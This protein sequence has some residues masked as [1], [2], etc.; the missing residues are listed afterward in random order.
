MY[1]LG[2]HPKHNYENG[3]RLDLDGLPEPG[4]V[5]WPNQSFYSTLDHAVGSYK[6]KYMKGEEIAVVESVG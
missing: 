1:R 6:P 3:D 4:A 2:V 5:V